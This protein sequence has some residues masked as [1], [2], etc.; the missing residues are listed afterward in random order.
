MK[1]KHKMDRDCLERDRLGYQL[2]RFSNHEWNITAVL[3]LA[4][5]LR[6][7]YCYEEKRHAFMSQQTGRKFL[8]FLAANATRSR[9]IN[10][11]WYGG[12]PLLSANLM[13]WLSNNARKIL[14]ELGCKLKCSVITN[15]TL[16]TAELAESL[17]EAGVN[18][19]QITLD[20]CQ[21]D[22]DRRR[23]THK[24]EPT[25][26]KI[27][28][29]LTM[30]PDTMS[31]TVRVNVDK[32]N[33]A[34]LYEMLHD[35]SGLDVSSRLEI[36]FAPLNACGEGCQ[37]FVDSHATQLFTAGDLTAQIA[38]ILPTACKLGLSIRLP[39][40][41]QFLCGAVSRQSV[42]VEPDG[43]LKKCWIDVGSK[44]GV[45]GHLDEPLSLENA[46]LRS[47]LNYDPF[48]LKECHECEL[49]PTCLGGCPWMVRHGTKIP[50]R[51]HALKGSFATIRKVV[52]DLVAK[53]QADF[54]YERGVLTSHPEMSTP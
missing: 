9:T 5:N 15:A 18:N 28:G 16:L 26:A 14:S 1:V 38:T 37:G 40:R 17:S 42:V 7:I 11:I 21:R 41:D 23:I 32:E 10:L 44:N 27:L 8:M 36:Y 54:D 2:S 19:V 24:R 33:L 25:Y 53:R 4:C 49:F 46:N 50:D 39:L 48:T 47:W 51:C 29:A 35:L 31:V 6:C 13:I 12:E 22:H 45:V 52:D 34:G 43:T 3:N 30:F 20:G